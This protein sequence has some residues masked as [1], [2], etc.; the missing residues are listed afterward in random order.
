MLGNEE[1]ST[2]RR[3]AESTT[4]HASR[5]IA[6]HSSV[7]PFEAAA[8]S[9]ATRREYDRSSISIAYL[10]PS[11]YMACR[12]FRAMGRCRS[13]ESGLITA[14]FCTFRFTLTLFE[15]PA[16][17]SRQ[18]DWRRLRSD[19]RTVRCCDNSMG[20]RENARSMPHFARSSRGT[21]G[22]QVFVTGSTCD[23][24]ARC[25][26]HLRS[27]AP[28]TSEHVLEEPPPLPEHVRLVVCD[29]AGGAGDQQADGQQRGRDA[30]GA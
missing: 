12:A 1:V 13:G 6:G 8:S 20:F 3:L 10:T 29:R 24:N 28:A 11:Q 4:D 15:E 23:A 25:M 22:A 16:P 14:R 7:V 21:A 30:E 27:F 9:S 18:V 5:K 19:L 2:R 17:R 26:R